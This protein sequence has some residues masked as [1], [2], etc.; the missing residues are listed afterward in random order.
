MEADPR[1][2]ID[3]DDEP[4]GP[5]LTDSELDAGERLLAQWQSP[6]DFY[7]AT[8]AL[9]GRCQSSEYFNRPRLKFLHDAYVLAKFVKLSGAEAVRLAAPADQ[10]PDGFVRLQGHVHNIEITSTH[11]G[12]KLGQEYRDVKGWRFDP[13]ED[14][15]ARA[16]AI[17][18]YLDEVINGKSKKN[19]ASPCWLVVYLNISE[20]GI[21]QIETE[22][23]IAATKAR[24]AAGFVAIS[25]LWKGKL[26]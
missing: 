25:V 6:P 21:R 10:W 12:R 19:Y 4:V 15:I 14:W 9:C 11:G 24:Y 8:K 22:Q 18:K 2:D 26:Y 1:P 7:T 17:P 3:D 20:Y 23:V 5:P 16:D 13:V